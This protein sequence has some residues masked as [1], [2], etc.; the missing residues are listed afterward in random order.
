MLYGAECWPVQKQHEHKIGVAEMRMLRWMCGHTRMDKI[1]ND[2]IR[3]KVGIAP[4]AEKMREHRLRWFGH[5]LRRPLNAPIRTEVCYRENDMKK[6]RGR[7]KLTWG[8]VVKQDLIEWEIDWRMVCLRTEW[9][10]A[11]RIVEG[12][13]SYVP[14]YPV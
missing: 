1:K 11:I 5:I 12:G 6:G 7:P 2:D 14:E 13:I 4:V 10:K 3:R 9:R 8:K